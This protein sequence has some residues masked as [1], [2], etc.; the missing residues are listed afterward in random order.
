MDKRAVMR[1]VIM[2]LE[3]QKSELEAGLNSAKQAAKDSPSAME[4]HSD[5]TRNQMQ[6]L[7]TNF[8]TM[9][10]EKEIAIRSLNKLLDSGKNHF[11]SVKDG[12]VIETEGENKEK[13]FYAVVPEGGAGATVNENGI[14]VTSITLK[15][16]LGKALADR[17]TGETATLLGKNGERKIK[18]LSII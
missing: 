17:K 15:T 4:S 3:R 1:G 9:A 10:E 6:I 13:R 14:M 12:A 2:E 8:K 16:P 7:A 11:D 18:I 5:T